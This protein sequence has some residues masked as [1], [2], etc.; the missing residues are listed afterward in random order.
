MTIVELFDNEIMDNVV[1]TLCLKPQRAVIL[2]TGEKDKAF[3]DTLNSIIARR[4]MK[5]E[6]LP[7]WVDAS[8]VE[9]VV[10]K[11]EDVAERFPDCDFDITGGEDMMLV[12]IGE[13]AKKLNRPMHVVDVVKNTVTG[14]NSDVTYKTYEVKLTV[15]ELIGLHSGRAEVAERLKET[16][17]W[18]RDARSEEDIEKV[19]EICRKDPSGWN[20]A[21][22]ALR[23]YRS[24]ANNQLVTIRTKLEKAGLVRK[25]KNG[26]LVYKNDVVKYL[27]SRQGT[28]LEMYTYIVAKD[29]GCFDDGQS[30]VVIDWKGKREVE[31][32]IDCLLTKGAVGYFISCKNGMV[33][34]NELYKLSTVANRFGG[35]YAKKIVV[36]SQFEPDASFMERANEMGI[37]IVKN[38]KHLSKKDFKKR[39]VL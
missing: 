15:E 27:L 37:K 21:I 2:Y 11:L 8:S 20:S 38:A 12:A 29:A 7:E 26:S 25:G 10:K 32:E 3:F 9:S 34:S 16:Y 22:G 4:G 17:T 28:A 24:D 1:G 14:I 35:R 13:V 6:I 39:I 36:I 33:D 31:N 23:G 19:W 5:T 30:G 18:Q